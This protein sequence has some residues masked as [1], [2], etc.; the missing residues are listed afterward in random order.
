MQEIDKIYF[1]K[2]IPSVLEALQKKKF[3][4]YFFETSGEAKQF[5]LAQIKPGETVGIGG[6]VTLRE[7][8]QIVQEIRK[9]GNTVYDHWEADDDPQRRIELKR[10]HRGVDVFLSSTNAIAADGTLVNLD[11]GGN[12]VASLCSG[13]KRVIVIAGANK[14]VES[15]D[16]AIRR[17]RNRAAVQR[18]LRSQYKT[19][20]E[21]T[22]VCS[23]CHAPQRICAA[24]LILM[25]KPAD[26]DQFTVV[27][28]NEEMGY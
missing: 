1:R 28:V 7:N 17:T 5:I 14:L 8:L 15:V 24:L 16:E 23:D 18:V 4:P 22:G 27:L 9:K 20:C 12:R 25:Q 13:P 26:I 21:V 10:S 19:P 11:G 3:D 6:S 2:K